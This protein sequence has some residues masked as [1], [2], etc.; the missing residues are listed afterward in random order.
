MG[1][2]GWKDVTNLLVAFRTFAKAAK[3]NST[4]YM[5]IC[6]ALLV[7]RS[8]DRFPVVSLD[9]SVTYFLQ[10]APWPWGRLNP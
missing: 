1:T 8:R 7:G 4:F 6:A 3:I 5:E 2:D 9:F 10:T